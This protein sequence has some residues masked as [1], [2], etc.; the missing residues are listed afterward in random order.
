MKANTIWACEWLTGHRPWKLGKKSSEPSCG[1][2]PPPHR[3]PPHCRAL[4]SGGRDST[5]RCLTSSSLH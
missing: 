1:P 3:T 4:G 2:A 5:G